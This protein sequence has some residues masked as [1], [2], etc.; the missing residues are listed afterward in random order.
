MVACGWVTQC[1]THSC[2]VSSVVTVSKLAEVPRFAHCRHNHHAEFPM[3]RHFCSVAF[4]PPT[5]WA[6]PRSVPRVFKD[7]SGAHSGPNA[8]G[9]HPVCPVEQ[10]PCWLGEGRKGRAPPRSLQT[11]QS[12]VGQG[13]HGHRGW[14]LWVW[15]SPTAH[16]GTHMAGA[17][18]RPGP[19]SQ[20]PL[21]ENGGHSPASSFQ[22]VQVYF[23]LLPR[24]PS[25]GSPRALPW[26]VGLTS[27]CGASAR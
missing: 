12:W 19:P 14:K 2:I 25:G 22:C 20:R 11:R 6:S 4:L 16:L 7:S 1:L 24:V 17:C 8:H 23:P 5:E 18:C 27:S 21:M 13:L 10:T 26:R 15:N 3:W 9:H